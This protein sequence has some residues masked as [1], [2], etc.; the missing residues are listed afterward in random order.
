VNFGFFSFGTLGVGVG[1]LEVAPATVAV[2][3]SVGA[4][5]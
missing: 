3:L 5:V 4:F 1:A 2:P